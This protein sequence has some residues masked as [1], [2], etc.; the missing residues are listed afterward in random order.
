MRATSGVVLAVGLGLA[1][2]ALA[3]TT[4]FDPHG[5]PA[6]GVLRVQTE[7][8]TRGQCTQC[9][10]QHADPV[11]ANSRL[12]FT[13]NDN[14][15][16]FATDGTSPC[17]QTRPTNYPLREIDRIPV[18]EPDAGYFEYNTGGVRRAGVDLR[19]RWPGEAVYTDTRLTPQGRYVSAHAHDPDMPLRDAG[20]E[21]L[22]LNCHDPHARPGRDLLVAPYGGISGQ[23]ESSAP[24]A[25]GLCFQCHGAGG[26]AGMDAGSRSIEDYYDTGLNGE[27]AGH[28]I[29]RNPRV[30]LSWPPHVQVGD[31][32]PCFD[33]HNVHGSEGNDRTRPNAS[34]ISDQRIDWSGLDRTLA[35]PAQARRFCLGCHIPSDGIPGTQDVEG[36][37]M[38]TLSPVQ[39][40]DSAALQGCYDCHGS[41]YSSPTAYNVHNPSPGEQ[42]GGL[43]QKP[44][45]PW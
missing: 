15:L 11:P 33:C 2:W 36:I 34:L 5:D 9:H 3:Q 39:G 10:P 24:A 29:R 44:W 40:H 25:Y 12:L 6:T 17:H 43:D 13:T 26:P 18:G 21:G 23:A 16:C 37:V 38:N 22:C 45:R 1:T 42:G 27:H 28:Q 31:K 8:S 7:P 30:A 35:D 20:G 4:E 14:R 32:L 41:D 19:G